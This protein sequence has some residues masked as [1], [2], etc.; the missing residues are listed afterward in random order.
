MTRRPRRLPFT[1]LAA[2]IGL[3]VIAGG[4]APG[5]PAPVE[6]DR[7]PAAQAWPA[8][9]EAFVRQIYA[10]VSRP[11]GGTPDWDH[12]R[13]YFLD[14]ALIVLRTT[15]TATTVFD[16]DGF[17][18]GSVA[19]LARLDLATVPSPLPERAAVRAS[20]PGRLA[21]TYGVG[22][23]IRVRVRAERCHLFDPATGAAIRPS[24]EP[25]DRA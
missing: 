14:R 6:P 11:D 10:D 24:S 16:V 9:A 22:D 5:S 13:G 18:W 1:L 21:F 25:T 17:S 23:E 19:A 2:A 12:V 4:T 7:R 3:S 15:R 8:D 20:V